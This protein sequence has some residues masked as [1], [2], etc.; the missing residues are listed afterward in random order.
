MPIFE[1]MMIYY[2]ISIIEERVLYCLR[3]KK[4]LVDIRIEFWTRIGEH[5]R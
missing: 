2:R 4:N 5:Q 1:G 3:I